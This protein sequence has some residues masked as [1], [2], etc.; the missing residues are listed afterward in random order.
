MVLTAPARQEA[1]DLIPAVIHRDG[2]SRLQIVRED[3]DPLIHAYLKA[4]GR[5][6]GV[7]VS[8]NTSLNVGSPIV[9]SPEQ[10]LAALQKSHGLHALFLVA[11]D[12]ACLVAWHNA[13]SKS[14]DSGRQLLQWIEDWKLE[15]ASTADQQHH[16]CAAA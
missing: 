7:E 15:T 5:R 8:V 14:K 1:Y 3:V 12:G 16:G 2:T 10:A 13:E 9:Q 4:M 11:D 6:T